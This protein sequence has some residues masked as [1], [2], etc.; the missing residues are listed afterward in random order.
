MRLKPMRDQRVKSTESEADAV[1]N[2]KI[3]RRG[4]VVVS[5][6][7]LLSINVRWWA[8]GASSAQIWLDSK[9]RPTKSDQCVLYY[10]STRSTPGYL[11]LDYVKAGPGTSFRTFRGAL[12]VLDEIARLRGAIAIF[13]HVGTTAISDRLLE[14]WG[15]QPHAGKLT[16]RHWIKRFYEGYPPQDLSHLGSMARQLSSRSV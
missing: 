15:W 7:Q 13:A 10:T 2:L 11:T 9:F 14:R 12:L 3:P 5:G 16:G 1:A 4:K 8:G 6:G